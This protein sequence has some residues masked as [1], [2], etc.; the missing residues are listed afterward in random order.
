M[1]EIWPRY[2]W[3]MGDIANL[4]P[5][6]EHAQHLCIAAYDS[7]IQI[8]SYFQFFQAFLGSFLAF[9]GTF[10]GSSLA[11]LGSFLAF[12]G[13]FS[14]FLAFLTFSGLFFALLVLIKDFKDH[15]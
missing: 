9:L 15:S 4:K 12:L 10:L 6:K 11:F 1:T 8:C 2:G 3:G 14:A 13:S 5:F 7:N